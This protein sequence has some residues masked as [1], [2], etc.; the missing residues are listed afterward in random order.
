MSEAASS[1]P[2]AVELSAYPLSEHAMS[3]IDDVE[4][5]L[6]ALLEKIEPGREPEEVVVYVKRKVA[7]SFKNGMAAMA[8]MK[9]EKARVGR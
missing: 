4:R 6:R 2:G 1:L 5:Q 9:E 7:D 3:Y 8:R